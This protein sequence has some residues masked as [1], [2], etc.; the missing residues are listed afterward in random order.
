MGH[1]CRTCLSDIVVGHSCRTLLL[2]GHSSGTL[3][4]R[5]L[6]Q[7][8]LVEH[9]CGTLLLE[10]CCGQLLYTALVAHSC[11]TLRRDPVGHSCR[12]LLGHSWHQAFK[13]SISLE[14]SEG[15]SLVRASSSRSPA[16]QVYN[17]RRTKCCTC[18]GHWL[19]HASTCPAK[20]APHHVSPS[21]L[22]LCLRSVKE[23]GLRGKRFNS[24]SQWTA[25]F[26]VSSA[27]KIMFDN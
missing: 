4:C 24:K 15:G 12:T 23:S 1:S 26:N 27:A 14:T 6:L 5:T 21:K 7:D 22:T 10:N 2:G 11:K 16:Q 9:F 13:T 8:T 20:F 17:P 18:H 3:C 19:P 25:T